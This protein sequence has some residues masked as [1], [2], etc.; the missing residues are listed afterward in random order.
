M[1][2]QLIRE[3][4]RIQRY[5][6]HNEAEDWRFRTFLKVRLDLSNA[7]LDA[8]VQEITD[9]I[10]KQID[11]LSCGNCC[12]TLQIVVDDKDIKRLARRLGVSVPEFNRRYIGIAEDTTKHFQGTPCPFLGEGNVCSVYED[13]P[14]AC[15]DYPY[16]HEPNFRTRTISMIENCETCPIVFNVWQALK[17][18]FPK[19]RR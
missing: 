13:R 15:R 5:S 17:K 12:K 9:D 7:E 3:I 16:L 11:C 2:D 10:W 14:R 8:V 6:R 4:P 18:R 19:R 1:P